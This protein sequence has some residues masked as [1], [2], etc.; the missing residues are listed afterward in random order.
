MKLT[1]PYYSQ[2]LDVTNPEWQNRAC[3][4]VCLKMLLE[5]KGAQVPSL[6]EMIAQGDAIGAYGESGWKHDGLVALAKQYGVKLSCA[7]WRQSETKSLDELNQ[8][9]INTILRQLEA[10]S[11]V[12]VSIIKNFEIRDKFHMVLVVGAEMDEGIVKGFYYHDSDSYTQTKGANQFVL[13]P[14]FANAWR[15]M[16]IF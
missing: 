12:I 1:V 9:G 3:G 6:D 14:I 5:A 4:V 13:L 16:A 15:R 11:P 7:E 10:G 2:Y 8:D